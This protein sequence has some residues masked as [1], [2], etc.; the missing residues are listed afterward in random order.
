MLKKTKGTGFFALDI[1]QL[2]KIQSHDLGLEEAVTYLA[3]MKSTDESNTT[4]RGGI[5]SVTEYTGLTRAEAKRAIGHLTRV[6]LIEAMEVDRKRARTVPRY[7]LPAHEARPR[8][9]DK[10]NEVLKLVEAGTT[11]TGGPMTNAAYRVERKGWIERL[12]TGWALVPPSRNL[13]FIPNTFVHMSDQVSPLARLVQAGELG[14]IL[15][16]CELY[17]KQDLMNERGVPIRDLCGFFHVAGTINAGRKDSGYKIHMLREGRK[18]KEDGEE[19]SFDRVYSPSAFRFD[20]DSFWH[21]LRTL[22]RA[23]VIEWA[24]YSANG[25]PTDEYDRQRPQRPLGVLRNGKQVR[26]T[27]EADA[28]FIAYHMWLEHFAEREGAPMP[29]LAQTIKRWNEESPV[30][31]VENAHV[32]HVGAIGI[33]RMVH[34]AGT[35]N[36][37]QWFRDLHSERTRSIFFLEQ[38]RRAMFPQASDISAKISDTENMTSAISM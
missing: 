2:F 27:P 6:G 14:P 13:A 19:K 1:D 38:A 3:L 26:R 5:N 12:S 22:D 4:S 34:R 28:A 23:H 7:C 8:L 29:D 24:I 10:E 25:K 35:E 21:D 16:A 37:S 18:Y 31:V 33:C 20:D 30:V 15:L 36:M 9:T 11:I 32:Q 17:H